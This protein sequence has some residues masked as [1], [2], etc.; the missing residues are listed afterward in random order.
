[1]LEV[2]E[3]IEYIQSLGQ[4]GR[5]YFIMED[6]KNGTNYFKEYLEIITEIDPENKFY[7]I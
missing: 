2:Y 6:Y 5:L 3:N 7:K 1:M 4:L